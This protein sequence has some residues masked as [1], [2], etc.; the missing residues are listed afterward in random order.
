MI[1]CEWK[2]GHDNAAVKRMCM[3]QRCNDQVACI[4]AGKIK[5]SHK[6]HKQSHKPANY[7]VLSKSV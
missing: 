3:C 4:Q 1:P 6:S 2:Y 7:G 5:L